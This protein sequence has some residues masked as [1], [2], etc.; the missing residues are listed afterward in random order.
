MTIQLILLKDMM[1]THT[2]ASYYIKLKV[3]MYEHYCKV[4]K[5]EWLF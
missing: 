5:N 3:D 4:Y 2:N 1:S